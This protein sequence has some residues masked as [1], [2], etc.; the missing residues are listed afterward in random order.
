MKAH[1]IWYFEMVII[2]NV[3]NVSR[4]KSNTFFF[5]IQNLA[6]NFTC[7]IKDICLLSLI[8][9]TILKILT[10]YKVLLHIVTFLTV[11]VKVCFKVYKIVKKK[12]TGEFHFPENHDI[13]IFHILKSC[14]KKTISH[15]RKGE[16]FKN[17]R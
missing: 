9:S 1:N 7:R 3:V 11:L 4:I 12:K 17:K 14:L 15:R 10:K 13:F 5:L 8:L 16:V 6:P 2:T